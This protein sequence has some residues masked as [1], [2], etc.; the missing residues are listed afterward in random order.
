MR[1][2]N[3]AINTN[4]AEIEENSIIKLRDYGYDNP[5]QAVN[6]YMFRTLSNGISFFGYREESN[7]VHSVLTFDEKKHTLNEAFEQVTESLK[8][9]FGIR[10]IKTYPE[11]ITMFQTIDCLNEGRRRDYCHAGT[12]FID[13]LNL[14]TYEYSDKY[15]RW[16]FSIKERIIPAGENNTQSI[17]DKNFIAELSNIREHE[18]DSNYTGN[19]VHYII[20]C[21]SPEAGIEMTESLMNSLYRAN[22]LSSRRMEIIS[23]IDPITINSSRAHIEDLIENNTGGTVVFDLTERFGRDPVDYDKVCSFIE[24]TLKRHR[25]DCLFVFIYN[26]ENPGFAYQLLPNLSKYVIPMTLKEG[27]GDRKAAVRYMK[28]LI[29]NSEYSKYANQAAEFMKQYPGDEF[30]QTDVLMAFE[31]FGPWCLNKNILKSYNIDSTGTFMLDRDVDSES[32][33]EKLQK[34]IGLETV[35]KQIDSILA[36]D[37]VEKERKKRNSRNSQSQTMHMVFAGNP[38]TAKTTVAELF[39]GIAKEKGIL[40]SGTIVKRGGMDLD[41]MLCVIRIRDAFK[42]AKGGV[43]FIDEAY[44]IQSNAATT[45]LIQEMENRRDDVIVIMAGYSE[46][47]RAFM[48]INEGMKSRVPYWV[49]FPDYSTEEL[50]EIFK[51]M[52]KQRNLSVT[53]DAVNEA[54]YIFEKMRNTENFGN[55]RYVRNLIDHALQN[56]AVRLLDKRKESNKIQ[57]KELSQIC[58]EDISA[59]DEGL[60][61]RRPAGSAKAELDDMIGLESVKKVINRA[62]GYYKYNKRCLEKGMI[63]EKPSMHMMFSGNPGTAKSTV[64]RLFGEIM[65][66]EKVLATGK[67]VEVGRA[68]LVGQYVGSTAKIVKQKFKEAQGGIL[69]IDEAYSLVDDRQNSFGDEAINTIVQEMENCRDNTVVIFAGYTDRMKQFL[70]RNPGMSSRL[71]FQIDF[72]DY[73]TDELCDI[74]KLMASKKQMVITDKAMKKLHDNFE[75]ARLVEGYGNG[76]YVRNCLEEAEMN[77]AERIM[78]YKDSDITDEMMKTIEEC[79]IPDEK[80][81]QTVE[82]KQIGFAC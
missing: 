21:R 71:A 53:D 23:E 47:M 80:P 45:A 29:K 81:L 44:A 39:A 34:L 48:D 73:T 9:T 33:Y 41:G 24:A 77:L 26:I 66:D 74:A 25:N 68:T 32:P 10:K 42:A 63:K 16:S 52:T 37:L 4:S 6:N 8:E 2:Y 20:S 49:D 55:G 56:Q 30:T 12:R 72:E 17:Y 11:E 69:F 67:F 7:T 15:T 46:R 1:Y 3:F 38:G 22:R 14:L 60:Q 27:K 54:E 5:I 28:S 79:D 35:K 57:N 31:S 61:E 40:K 58:K 36:F 62:I 59:L 13:S 19:M 65:R 82:T 70:E 78:Q 75:K 18:N 76:R 64:A 43:L 50:V 51:L